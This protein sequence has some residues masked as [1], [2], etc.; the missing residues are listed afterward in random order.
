MKT[1]NTYFLKACHDK[2]LRIVAYVFMLFQLFNTTPVEAQ[3]DGLPRGAY[4]M[5]YKRY[6]A[7]STSIG[8]GATLLGPTFDQK[9]VESEASD[10][11]CASLSVQ[12]S[13]VRWNIT[14]AA[15]GLVLRFSMPDA[16][17][18]GGQTGSLALYVGNTFIQNISL[19]SKWAWQYFSPNRGD[20]TKDPTN[21]PSSGWTQRMRF[22]EVRVKLPTQVAVGSEI[23]LQKTN[24]D[25]ITYI[26]DFIEMEPI[27]DPI[28]QPANSLSV[29][30]YGANP[31][32]QADDMQAFV[33][34][35]ND[36][37]TQGKN[38]YIPEGR[39][40]LGSQGGKWMFSN[41]NNLTVQGAGMWHT[42]L[43]FSNPGPNS[44]GIETNGSNLHFKDFYMNTENT[45]RTAG[46]KGFT[47]G[48]G[49]N[50]S[51]ER[52][53]VEHF[54]VGAWIANWQSS[55][56][57]DGLLITGS[58]FR[59]NYA[60]GVNFSKGTSN[61]ICEH[62]NFRNN[63]DDA[64]ASWSSFDGPASVNNEFRY[65]TA[66]HTWR[67]AG[68]GF[69]G[70]G[71]HRGH[72]LLIKDNTE[73]GIRVNSDFPGPEFSTTLWM[74]IYETTVISCGTNANLWFNRYG[75]VDIFTRLYNLQ[76]LRLRNVDILNSQKDAIMIYNVASSYRI[77]NLELINVTI[78]GTGRD[79]NV[80]NYTPET[81][82]DYLGHGLLVLPQVNGFM[83]TQNLVIRNAAT[84][85]IL[86]ES[87]T[88]FAI[89]GI[90]AQP[91]V[92]SNTSLPSGTINTPYNASISATNNPTTYGAT[93]LPAGL[94]VNAS[95]GV[96]SGTPT[97]AGNFN[98]TLSATNSAGAA[99]KQLSLVVNQATAPVISN[100]SLPDGVVNTAYS[101]GITASNNPTSFT[102]SGLP[103]GLS[104]NTSTG[105]ISG[106]PTAT[107]T[108]TVTL[109]ASN[110][111]GTGTK[112]LK[113]V[114]N[115]PASQTPYGGTARSI[116]GTIQAEDFDNG[117]EGISYHDADATNSG[118]QY[119]TT[120]VDIESCAEGGYN[121]GWMRS[122]EWLEYTVNVSTAGAYTLQARVASGLSGRT[123]HVELDGTNIS[124]TISVPNTGN[125]QTWQTV[126]V[127]T[128]AL[129]TG[130]K[131]LR[132][133]VDADDFNLNYLTFTAT[134]GGGNSG[135]T[136]RIKNRWQN[137]YL[138]DAGDRVRYAASPSGTTYEWTLEDVGGGFKELKNVSTGEYMHIE[139]LQG[140]VQCTA[141]T[142]GWSS[143]RWTV[144]DA[145]SGF[146]RLKNAWQSNQY[147]HVENLQGHAQYG[148][149]N[150]SWL[151]AQWVLE[152]TAGRSA[153]TSTVASQQNTFSEETPNGGV[154]T[155]WPNEVK[156]E[157]FIR[158]NGQFEQ[159]QIIDLTG[160]QW[161]SESIG[162][163]DEVRLDVRS[164]TG[165]IHIVKLRGRS[166][167]YMFRIIKK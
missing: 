113:L 106:T 137:T 16:P 165:G 75:A 35:L 154:I 37:R 69:F 3:S 31:N 4:Q 76:N 112:Q 28:G 110:S 162:G 21:S 129:T 158:T 152:S 17:G 142:L 98:V 64:M 78:D 29:T 58:R 27:P 83:S 15:R 55:T 99:T 132:I 117:G 73:T 153:S 118:G 60:D 67:A 164:L 52:V 45:N 88:T 38:I 11:I 155:Y 66:E 41:V 54:E 30:S 81:Y 109:S 79:N 47:G 26:V 122:T 22:D 87:S 161:F 128:P 2:V 34:C 23:R 14:Q 131:V 90:T 56:I 33:N 89:N 86:N 49:T 19:T 105:V 163:K 32:D 24:A 59:N 102:A 107:G 51:I 42:E 150:A 167:T 80:N 139:N 1:I 146:V 72:H 136:Y 145:G 134:N 148:T 100:T 50:S 140:Y 97:V 93:G 43:Y 10:Q 120:G 61:S 46:Y 7:S 115:S 74:E 127:T 147:I 39:F 101:A 166:N 95:T 116:P 119:R 151:S 65:C 159:A 71:G 138:Y 149:I 156:E 12:N 108:F 5:P 53:W 124:G 62:S 82:D 77:T 143:S 141:R 157:L 18:G 123:F 84:A 92:I 96:I 20:G 40:L 114:V 70:G 9:K 94:T 85:P 125:W 111:G 91:P 57:T 44:G 144:E 68:I 6:E 25:G 133:V 48:Y 103:A 126:S 160:R 104:V 36:A 121:V 130:Q 63:G 13:F 135:V 8:G